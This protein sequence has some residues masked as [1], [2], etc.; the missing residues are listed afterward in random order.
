MD[1]R[2][3]PVVAMKRESFKQRPCESRVPEV[4]HRGRACRSSNEGCDKRLEQRTCPIRLRKGVNRKREEQ[5]E[6]AK[7]FE[8]TKQE[9]WRAYLHVKRNGGA[10]GI[11]KES[12]SDFAKDEK[13]LLYK[14]WNRLSSGSYFPP[15]VRGLEIPKK[16]GGVRMLGIPT[17]ADRIAQQVAKQRLEPVLDP[18][19]HED[20]YGYR[21]NKSAIQAIDVT[22]R[23][24]WKMDW[25]LEFDIKGLFDNIDHELLM[26]AVRKHC[27][28]KWILLYVERWLKAPMQKPNGEIMTRDKGTPQGGVISPLLS[29]LFL[30]YTFDAWMKR[31]YPESPFARFADD[32]VIHCKSEQ[33]AQEL[34]EKLKQRFGECMLELHPT[35]TKIVYC[36]DG[37]RRGEYGTQKFKFLGYTFQPRLSHSK[38]KNNYFVSF[39]PAVSR[40]AETSFRESI[41]GLR[42]HARS[43]LGIEDIAKMINPIVRGWTGYFGHFLPSRMKRTLTYLDRVLVAWAK[44]KYKNLRGT[45]RKARNWLIRV[46]HKAQ[47]LFVH[48]KLGV[49]PGR[50]K[51]KAPTSAS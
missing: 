22:R 12:L 33:Q 39:S 25:V 46:A 27:D 31:N 50:L 2:G 44:R 37:Y 16:S 23:R 42:I 26:K 29:N 49:L 14:L 45:G 8:I 47:E 35:K 36:K 30:H 51:G 32:A 48:W 18:L 10:A 5:M 34:L 20:S 11:D 38:R 24:C 19:F 7:V 3:E 21:A 1:G 40:E 41:R 15:A 9:V 4:L 43:D 28:T 13:N 17:V 6:T